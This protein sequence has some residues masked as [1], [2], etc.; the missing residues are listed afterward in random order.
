MV[1]GWLIKRLV[2][3]SES[4]RKREIIQPPKVDASQKELANWTTRHV[5]RLDNDRQ[6]LVN[7]FDSRIAGL[8]VDYATEIKRLEAEIRAKSNE[9][10]LTS[11]MYKKDGKDP[12]LPSIGPLEDMFNNTVKKVLDKRIMRARLST[13]AGVALIGGLVLGGV[14]YVVKTKSYDKNQEEVMAVQEEQASLI[15]ELRQGLKD[16]AVRIGMMSNYTS[17][18]YNNALKEISYSEDKMRK[19]FSGV[20]NNKEERIEILSKDNIQLLDHTV[21]LEGIISEQKEELDF[22]SSIYSRHLVQDSANKARIE[23]IANGLSNQLFRTEQK[24]NS[25]TEKLNNISD[26]KGGIEGRLEILERHGGVYQ[27]VDDL[28]ETNL[29][30]T[31]RSYKEK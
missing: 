28:S 24:Y 6:D 17:Q 29:P 2:R 3:N 10:S 15:D 13:L 5:R 4:F 30:L 20:I 18:S 1:F 31:L 22:S 9:K 11:L 23:A 8:E 16:N 12:I 21:Y 26:Q 27:P 7:S 19:A 25:L 14:Y